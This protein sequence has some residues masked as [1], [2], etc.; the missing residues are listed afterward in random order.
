MDY[1]N[2]NYAG[3][4][5]G[6]SNNNNGISDTLNQGLQFQKYLKKISG[7]DNVSGVEQFTP[8]SMYERGEKEKELIEL[9]EQYIALVNNF[10]AAGN[11]LRSGYTVITP[12]PNTNF[13]NKHVSFAGNNGYVTKHGVFKSYDG[14]GNEFDSING[15]PPTSGRKTITGSSLE[16]ILSNYGLKKGAP[17]KTGQ[18]CGDEG[19]NVFVTTSKVPGITYRGC[20]QA[21]DPTLSGLK[22]EPGGPIYNVESCKKRTVDTGA[23]AFALRNYDETTKYA[24]C[25]T[26]ATF[27]SPTSLGGAYVGK[28]LWTS[29]DTPDLSGNFATPYL[30]K[31]QNGGFIS[32]FDSTSLN[33]QLVKQIP[34]PGQVNC[35]KVPEI[36][37]FGL[38]TTGNAPFINILTEATKN[39]LNAAL[40]PKT[41]PSFSFTIGQLLTALQIQT[42]APTYQLAYTCINGSTA[43]ISPFQTINTANQALWVIINASNTCPPVSSCNNYHLILKNNGKMQI[44]EGVSPPTSQGEQ[45]GGQQGPTPVYNKP[46]DVTNS[47]SITEATLKTLYPLY[48]DATGDNFISSTT[49]LLQNQYIKSTNGTLVL[50]MQP[51]GHLVLRTFTQPYNCTSNVIDGKSYGAVD[52]Y[53]L[54]NFNSPMDNSNIGELA[55]I[56]DDG[57]R[58]AYPDSMIGFDNERYEQSLNYDSIGNNI[59]NMPIQN[60]TKEYC[61]QVSSAN[62]NSGGFVYDSNRKECWIKNTSFTLK[63]PKIYKDGFYLNVKKPVPNIPISCSDTITEIDSNRWKQYKSSDN[64]F[65]DFKCGT[66]RMYS[67]AQINVKTT[68]YQIYGM[69]VEIINKMNALQS[70]GVTLSRDMASFKTQL[71]DSIAAYN[72]ET[73]NDNDI[74]V[75]SALSGMM[76]DADLMV[77]QENTRYLFLSIFAVGFMVVALNAIKK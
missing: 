32:I 21:S 66:A 23:A 28:D 20:Y 10:E 8:M 38:P 76:G 14:S 35:N 56:D 37:H 64:M 48:T 75:N 69:A 44:Y 15:C 67:S 17:M 9:K 53:A 26:S 33:P 40:N 57:L 46:Y 39:T 42:P 2:M 71:Q 72:N 74:V 29:K 3:S 27:V 51:D 22:E 60:S 68:E 13:T 24:N 73:N 62:V 63:T 30:M 1:D 61:K 50:M 31:V 41:V 45:S 55:Y 43:V 52:S 11:T 4:N 6:S 34:N 12:P 77:L 49:P 36:T 25:Y 16:T 47:V 58:H 18:S 65:N 59:S 54:Y 19:T 5:G 70:Q 7:F